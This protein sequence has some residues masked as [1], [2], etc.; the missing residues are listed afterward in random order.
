MS[1]VDSAQ[2][3]EKMLLAQQEFLRE[4]A[5]A[6]RIRLMKQELVLEQERNNIGA[7]QERLRIV[8][9]KVQKQSEINALSIAMAEQ[10]IGDEEFK[11]DIEYRAADNKIRSTEFNFQ[12]EAENAWEVIKAEEAT[13]RLRALGIERQHELNAKEAN[14]Q[15]L[16]EESIARNMQQRLIELEHQS[17]ATAE[18]LVNPSELKQREIALQEECAY[19]DRLRTQFKEEERCVRAL[20]ESVVLEKG[21]KMQIAF[22]EKCPNS[23]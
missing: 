1:S 4:E 23:T 7:D 10:R 5:D 16:R 15:K 22:D 13:Q 17:R 14:E 6:E 20:A 9:G 2:H 3:A 21:N 19:K 18:D 8:A 12:E 11:A